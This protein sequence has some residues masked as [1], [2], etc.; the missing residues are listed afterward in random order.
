MCRWKAM[1][2]LIWFIDCL[3]PIIEQS[4]LTYFFF[5]NENTWEPGDCRNPECLPFTKKSGNFGWNLNGKCYFDLTDWKISEI[6]EKSS[7]VVQNSQPE[8]PNEKCA[9]H[10]LF[11]VPSLPACI[12]PCGDV[13]GNATCT[14]HRNFHSA[15][16]WVPFT[17]TFDQPVF[18]TKW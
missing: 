3:F 15:F 2:Y 5:L 7:E 11:L 13:R 12:R 18:P 10:L 4:E 6:N 14:S 9:F 17:G 8:Y 1:F 16:W